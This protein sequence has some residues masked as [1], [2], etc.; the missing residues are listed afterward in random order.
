MPIRL[1]VLVSGRGSNLEAIL[2]SIK[3]GTL[4]AQVAVVLS[5]KP[6]VRALSIAGQYEVPSI[7]V[8]STGLSRPEHEARVIAE[9]E[10]FQI[11]YL[12][13]AG[14]MRI[15]SADFLKHF[16]DPAGYYRIINIHPSLLPSFP[17]TTAYDDAFAAGVTESGITVHLV[18]EGMDHGTVLAQAKFARLPEDTL[19]DFTNRGLTLEHRLFPAVLQKIACGE[20]DLRRFALSKKEHQ[21]I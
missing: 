10:R 19:E 1:A 5:N 20:I 18:D 15:L 7:V 13:L 21:H 14:Y 17:G 11:D 3:A 2:K 8:E 16:R 6:E 4:D 12:V 9:L